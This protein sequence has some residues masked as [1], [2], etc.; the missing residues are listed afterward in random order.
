MLSDACD[1]LWQAQ[2][3]DGGWHS[4]HH[5]FLKGGQAWTPFVL[6][7]LLQVPDSIYE[8]KPEQVDAAFQFIAS[9]LVGDSVLGIH[10]PDILE[11][12]NYATA[13]A[14]RVMQAHRPSQYEKQIAAMCNYL[15]AQ[16]FDQYRQIQ[17]EN[18]AFGGWGFGETMLPAGDVGHLDL[19]HT[20]RV[21]Q[22]LAT[23][24]DRYAFERAKSQTFL[25]MCQ[26]WP[27]DLRPQPGM[28]KPGVEHIFDGGFYYSPIIGDANKG[29]RVVPQADGEWY[30]QSY[31]TATCDG[32]LA[33]LSAGVAQDDPRVQA[34]A[35]WLRTNAE[36][37]FP[38]GIPHEDVNQ[39]HQVMKF[40]HLSVRAEAMAAL[41]MEG[42]WRQ[43][44]QKILQGSQAANGSFANPH[45][46]LNKED[47]PLMC[48]ALAIIAAVHA[49]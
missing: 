7:A 46:K 10:D 13:Y 11:Y 45:G 18:A 27:S 4:N 37:A 16:Q 24:E 28:Q 36:L 17:P 30:Y 31:A 29:K 25:A 12:P 8:P 23:Q 32:A 1:Y 47:D 22:A 34:A 49:S 40:Y 21:L 44:I 26:K 5:G 2:A 43:E 39:W 9:R 42:S 33:L 14:V 35:T 20:R 48:T 6:Y 15:A 19:S 3:D 41:E 38:E